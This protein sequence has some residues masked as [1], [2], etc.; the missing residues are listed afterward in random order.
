MSSIVYDLKRSIISPGRQLPNCIKIWLNVTNFVHLVKDAVTFP[1]FQVFDCQR[2]V[3]V[4]N[5]M[6]YEQHQ[7]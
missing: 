2:A 6:G 4:K 7:S 1:I 3:L 5:T